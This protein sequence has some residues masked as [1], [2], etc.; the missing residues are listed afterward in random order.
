MV[1]GI[2]RVIRSAD[3]K[4]GTFYI[5]QNFS[6]ESCIIQCIENPQANNES[7]KILALVFTRGSED[8]LYVGAFPSDLLVELKEVNVRVDPPSING[9]KFTT[10][11]KSRMLIIAGDEAIIMAPTGNFS[12]QWAAI[13]LNTAKVLSSRD[14]GDWVSFARWSLVAFDAG[15]EIEIA[16]FEAVSNS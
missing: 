4:P 10:S 7:D 16:T 13:N 15:E 2:G 11:I 8:D 12:Y 6:G 3:A 14:F 1:L 9:S 5:C